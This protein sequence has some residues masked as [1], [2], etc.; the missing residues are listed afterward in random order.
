MHLFLLNVQQSEHGSFQLANGEWKWSKLRQ[1][2]FKKLLKPCPK[3]FSCINFCSFVFRYLANL[4]DQIRVVQQ[5]CVFEFEPNDEFVDDLLQRIYSF[6][7]CD[8]NQLAEY[9]TPVYFNS[10]KISASNSTIK[11]LIPKKR[12]NI[13]TVTFV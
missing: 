3:F 5:H 7:D 2:N 6:K 12:S 8:L 1:K 9:N 10:Q 11:S 13:Q 4:V